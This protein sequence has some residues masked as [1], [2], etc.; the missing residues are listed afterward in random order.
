MME[1]VRFSVDIQTLLPKVLRNIESSGQVQPT[2]YA[3]IG[4]E[5]SIQ[6]FPFLHF[7]GDSRAKAHLLFV[8]GR[9][10]GQERMDR[11]LIETAFVTEVWMTPENQRN[12]TP[13]KRPPA[14]IPHLE[15]VLFAS[16]ANAAP[17]QVLVRAYRI[18]RKQG[19]V[20]DLTLLVLECGP[21][22]LDGLGIHPGRKLRA[23]R[24]YRLSRGSSSLG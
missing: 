8:E 6:A 1:K 11:D 16:A 14:H 21:T 12:P 10:L 2:V 23:G 4:Q 9:V 19:K 15:A 5:E 24:F 17:F 20:S 22:R 3:Q 18:K 13:G 7:V